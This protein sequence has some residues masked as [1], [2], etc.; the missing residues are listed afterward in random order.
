MQTTEKDYRNINL[1]L[2]RLTAAGR[3]QCDDIGVFAGSAFGD[4]SHI[5]TALRLIANRMPEIVSL[6][7]AIEDAEFEDA[8]LKTFAVAPE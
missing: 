8:L 6:A 7:A 4:P 5:R 1:R 3:R 2:Q